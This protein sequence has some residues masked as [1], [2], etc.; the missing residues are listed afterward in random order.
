[1]ARHRGQYRDDGNP[2]CRTVIPGCQLGVPPIIANGPAPKAMPSNQLSAIM[3]LPNRVSP[4]M[5]GKFAVAM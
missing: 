5:A 3:P 4:R 1:M 2:P